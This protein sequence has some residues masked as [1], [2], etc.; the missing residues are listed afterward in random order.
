MQNG[1]PVRNRDIPILARV[2]YAMQ[3]ARHAEDAC[4]YAQDRMTGITR[5]LT[6]MPHG[7]SG[8]AGFEN[9]YAALEGAGERYIARL[10]ASLALLRK[11]EDILNGIKNEDARTFAVMLYIY[12]M[13]AEDIRSELNMSPWGFRQARRSMEQAERMRFVH[14]SGRWYEKAKGTD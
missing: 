3:D 13:S 11:A 14:W 4:A 5:Y 7:N 8:K 9:A 1:R 2:L 12:G 6:G 10:E